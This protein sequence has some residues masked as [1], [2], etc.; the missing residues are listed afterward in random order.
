MSI[1]TELR[2][3]QLK[4]MN[5]CMMQCNDEELFDEWIWI[6]PDEASDADIQSIAMDDEAYND[7]CD[8]FARLV[9]FDGFKI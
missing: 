8:L 1:K 4:A 3:R 9:S 6:F 7:V 5:T 2:I